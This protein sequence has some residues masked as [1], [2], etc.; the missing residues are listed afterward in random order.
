MVSELVECYATQESQRGKAKRGTRSTT[1]NSKGKTNKGKYVV[2]VE[3]GHDDDDADDY[4]DV[5]DELADIEGDADVM[6]SDDDLRSIDS[7]STEE[8]SGN[9]VKHI[10]FNEKT[11]ME[12]LISKVGMKF[13]THVLF[14]EAMKEHAIKCGKEIKF[15]KSDKRQV[16]ATCKSPCLWTIY[17]SYVP[18]DEVYRVKTFIDEHSCVRSFNVPWVSTKWI[19][20]KYSERIRKNPTWP[21]LSLVD[22]IESEKI[23][24]VNPQKAYRAR[25]IALDMLQGSVAK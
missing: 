11:D 10:V 4:A 1:H 23:M 16:R 24:K 5:V 3:P 7:D 14:R 13:K 25:K 9:R 8:G 21:I 2:N 20:K 15:F 12:N 19:V 6:T 17:C 22:A 18:N